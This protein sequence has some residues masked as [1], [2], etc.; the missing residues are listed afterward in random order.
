[1]HYYLLANK[2]R[3]TFDNLSIGQ[4]EQDF[5][6]EMKT[7]TSISVSKTFLSLFL[8][9]DSVALSLNIQIYWAKFD[10]QTTP[11]ALSLYHDRNELSQLT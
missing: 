1:M 8:S 4:S 5:A 7:L 6:T 9:S 10:S 11:M 2:H 3:E